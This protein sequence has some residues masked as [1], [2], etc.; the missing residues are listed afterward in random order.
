[1]RNEDHEDM[2]AATLD[3]GEMG[4]RLR[5]EPRR[6]EMLPLPILRS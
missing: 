4:P 3:L 5:F 1:M 6:K 2:L